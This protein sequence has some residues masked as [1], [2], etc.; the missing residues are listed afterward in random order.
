MTP[1]F[2]VPVSEYLQFSPFAA[3]ASS[4][5]RANEIHAHTGIDLSGFQSPERHDVVLLFVSAGGGPVLQIFAAFE[6][7]Q[8]G[9]GDDLLAGAGLAGRAS[10]AATAEHCRKGGRPGCRDD[11]QRRAWRESPISSVTTPLA[12]FTQQYGPTLERQQWLWYG[13]LWLLLGSAYFICRCLFDLILVQRPALAPNLQTGG[14]AWLAGAAPWSACW[15]RSHIGERIVNSIRHCANGTH[16]VDHDAAN[17]GANRLCR[18][19]P[20]EA[21]AGLGG[22]RAGVRVAAQ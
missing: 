6:R 20:V 4:R 19:D 10:V 17:A 13:Y 5:I 11:R 3:T 8:S 16:T 18:G 12:Q 22:D 1:R 15:R 7:P 9:R 14:L 21:L 2:V